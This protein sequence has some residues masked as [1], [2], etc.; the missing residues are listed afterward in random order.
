VNLSLTPMLMVVPGLLPG[1]HGTVGSP[2]AVCARIPKPGEPPSGLGEAASSRG[3]E[4]WK[5]Q[6]LG[7]KAK[8]LGGARSPI[9]PSFDN[10]LPLALILLIIS[11]GVMARFWKATRTVAPGSS[12]SS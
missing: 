6:V 8:S 4:P 11:N 1:L 9:P 7:L 12:K 10:R 5:P 3:K 2:N